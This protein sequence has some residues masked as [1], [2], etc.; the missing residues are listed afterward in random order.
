MT[1]Q[2]FDERLKSGELDAVTKG[3]IARKLNLADQ[4]KHEHQGDVA[5]RMELQKHTADFVRTANFNIVHADFNYMRIA[6]FT[7]RPGFY[8]GAISPVFVNN[9]FKYQLLRLVLLRRPVLVSALAS[10]GRLVVGLPLPSDLGSAADL[11]PPGDLRAVRGL[12]VVAAAGLAA[13]AGRRLRHVGRC[14]ADRR[15]AA[16]I[17]RA[18]AGG[19]D[20]RSGP[21]RGKS[22]PALPRLVPQ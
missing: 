19:A 21:S 9:C 2:R 15:P 18:T 8:Y 5:R 3:D 13:A 12:D 11:V 16:G 17:R 22:R 14:R 1:H 7:P 10:V 20:G 6:G 4:Y